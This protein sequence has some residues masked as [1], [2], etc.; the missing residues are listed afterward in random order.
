MWVVGCRQVVA[1]PPMCPTGT[2][3]T[4]L[5]KQEQVAKQPENPPPPLSTHLSLTSPLPPRLPHSPPA[6]SPHTLWRITSGVRLTLT[7]PYHRLS[8]HHKRYTDW[9]RTLPHNHSA[10]DTAEEPHPAGSSRTPPS[11]RAATAAASVVQAGDGTKAPQ[12]GPCRQSWK[13][14]TFDPANWRVMEV[15]RFDTG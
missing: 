9:E 14:E 2:L 10:C 5:A 8:M 13:S 3:A 11:A 4:C 12:T 6:G 7:P 15:Q 1:L